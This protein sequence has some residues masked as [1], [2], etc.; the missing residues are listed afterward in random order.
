MKNVFKNLVGVMAIAGL[1]TACAQE[2]NKKENFTRVS[3][4]GSYKV[5]QPNPTDK[6]QP[7]AEQGPDQK[8][9][10]TAE[11]KPEQGPSTKTPAAETPP[12]APV[13]EEKT[14][15]CRIT[16]DEA[17]SEDQRKQSFCEALAVSIKEDGQIELKGRHTQENIEA[18]VFDE[19][20]KEVEIDT[21]NPK[22]IILEHKFTKENTKENDKHV[23]FLAYKLAHK[24]NE[25]NTDVVE[26]DV[27]I[28]GKVLN[29][30]K[31]ELLQDEVKNEIK[32]RIKDVNTFTNIEYSVKI[33]YSLK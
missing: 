24:L 14:T 23:L 30:D 2:K 9:N 20:L 19:K 3:G 21:Q 28:D 31:F 25:V 18:Y 1:L 7:T 16:D 15:L 4:G 27:I 12:V 10:P 17:L 33:T 22:L 5:Q 13:I 8:Q 11:Q 32:V 6:T 26:M 29:S